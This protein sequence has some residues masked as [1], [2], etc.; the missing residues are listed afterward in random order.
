MIKLENLQKYYNQH[1][2]LK[3][4]DLT[5]EKGQVVAIIGP[6]GSGK[7]T[8]LRSVNFL[9]QPT[10]GIVEINDKRVDVESATK[11]DILALRT[12]TG[13]VFQ[14]YNLF[15]NLT[16]LQNVMIGLTSVKH[17]D[18]KEAAKIS[19]EILEKVGLKERLNYYPSQ[20][21]G[22]QQQRVGIARALALDPEVILFD[23]PTSSLDPEL[24]D[25]VLTVIQNVANEGNTILLVTH[26]LDFAR[27]IADR[28]VF[29]EDGV[30][31]EEGTAEQIFTNPTVERTKQFI[32]K[33]LKRR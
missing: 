11:A 12:S 33:A 5:V 3:G 29:M 26:E 15:K 27:E 22:G 32:G 24:V 30:I 4:I 23:E 20:L 2:V 17:I 7:S 18:P 1:H 8:L 14:Q 21:S 31:V 6:S 13:M 10:S 25:E 9:E 19:V 16:V 28:V